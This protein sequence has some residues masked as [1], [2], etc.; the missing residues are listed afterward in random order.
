MRLQQFVRLNADLAVVLAA[1]L[2]TLPVVLLTT[3]L[4]RVGFAVVFLLFSPGYA[5]IAALYPRKDSID[6][7]ERLALSFGTS[8]AVVPLIG[9]L[10]NYT[11]WGIRLVPILISIDAAIFIFCSIAVVKRSRLYEEERFLIHFTLPHVEW[12]AMSTKD[13]I[14]TGTLTASIIFAIGVLFYVLTTPKQAEEFTEFY[15]LGMEGRADDYPTVVPAGQPV[16]IIIGIVNHE[17]EPVTYKVQARLADDSDAVEIATEAESSAK[18]N[19]H[20]FTVGPLN[21]EGEWENT[22]TVT[23]LVA[24]EQQQL[25][26]LLFNP[27]MR[28]GQTL[29]A[30]LSDDGYASIQID[31]G[32]GEARVTLA[33]GD[34]QDHTCSIEA[35]QSGRVASTTDFHVPHGQDMHENFEF[36]SGETM[37][38]LYDNGVLVLDDSGAELALHLWIDVE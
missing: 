15:V 23:P 31:E 14:L 24:G 4:I 34:N 17:G 5:L 27:R 9:L 32:K 25:Q 11:E 37:F 1:S 2:F 18:V 6:G 26:L 35:W 38:R 10:L 21:N 30:Q 12:H 22:T 3:G 19:S 8:I 13:R 20:T 29:R 36:P 16:D 33:A 28:V 7:I